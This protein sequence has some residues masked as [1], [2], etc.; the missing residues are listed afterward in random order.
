MHGEAEAVQRCGHGVHQERHV[1]VDDFDHRAPRAPALGI[2]PR[3]EGAQLGVA[4][5]AL[6]RELPER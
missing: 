3:I 4:R 1:V 5:R 6:L 2:E